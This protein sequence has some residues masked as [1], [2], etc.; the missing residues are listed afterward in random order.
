M[1]SN[2]RIKFTAQFNDDLDRCIKRGYDLN[3]LYQYLELVLDS[4]NIPRVYRTH[5]LKGIY[6]GFYE[7]HLKPDW[8]LIYV[9]SDLGMTL[10]RTGTHSDLFD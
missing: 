2:L 3:R 7:C 5:K 8:L 9:K 4:V 10:I 1:I 6:K